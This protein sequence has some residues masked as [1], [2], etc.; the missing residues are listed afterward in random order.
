[1]LQNKILLNSEKSEAM[2]I[3]TR[4]KLLHL[5][6]YRPLKMLAYLLHYRHYFHDKCVIPQYPSLVQ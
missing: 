5:H 4:Q 6:Q 3:E 2:L 1:M